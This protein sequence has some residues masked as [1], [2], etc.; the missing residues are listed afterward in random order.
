M[1][2]WNG[3][4]KGQGNGMGKGILVSL[5]CLVWSRNIYFFAWLQEWNGKGK[6][7][8]YNTNEQKYPPLKKYIHIFQRVEAIF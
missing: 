1:Q 6:E 3:K 7:N 5:I 4:G 8:N 2:E